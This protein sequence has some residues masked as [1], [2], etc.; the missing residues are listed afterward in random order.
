MKNILLLLIV[1]L[2]STLKADDDTVQKEVQQL[3]SLINSGNKVGI[4]SKILDIMNYDT[5]FIKVLSANGVDKSFWKSSL[6]EGERNQIKRRY[7]NYYVTN[8][9]SMLTDCKNMVL[10]L[11]GPDPVQSLR[12][13]NGQYTCN[14]D[15]GTR[16]SIELLTL[17]N[18][19]IDININ[20]ISFIKNESESG[21]FAKLNDL[22]DDEKKKLLLGDDENSKSN[23]TNRKTK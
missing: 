8:Y 12:K 13:Y 21:E 10:V 7:N 16:K 2:A 15:N 11:K 22:D 3:V 14:N 19:V 17:N 6:Q 9:F 23:K 5:F 20:G 4:E 1:F 18:K